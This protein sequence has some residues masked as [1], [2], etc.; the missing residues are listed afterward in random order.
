MTP[1]IQIGPLAFSYS[2]LLVLGSA[3]SAFIVGRWL[4]RSSA[5]E[6]ESLLWQTLIVGLV[7]ARLAFVAQYHE[8]YLASPL[9]IVDIRDGGWA[10][11][12][13]FI[14]AAVFVFVRQL[15]RP[16]VRTPLW[17][18]LATGAV[19]WGIGTLALNF[20]MTQRQ[21]LPPI[22][23]IS[24]DGKPVKLDD[25][26]GKPTVV[27]LWATWCPPCVREM[28]VLHQ[29]Q[30]DHP[31]VNFVFVNAGESAERVHAWLQMRKLPLK[32]VLLDATNQTTAHFKTPGFPTTLF[33][34]AGGVL[35]SVRVGEVSRA[36]LMERLQSV[37]AFAEK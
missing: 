15:R 3:A 4:G 7:A 19:I 33:F 35:V 36:T 2:L 25:F 37:G 30:V 28:P 10:P 13:G 23:L 18:A 12:V 11:L 9:G 26:K 8:A 20:G 32:N 5:H 22:A 34:D 14:G 17:S 21:T 1:G 31:D 24:M 6:V 27:N 29:A 16:R